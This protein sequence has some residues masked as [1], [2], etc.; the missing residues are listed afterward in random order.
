LNY[1]YPYFDIKKAPFLGQLSLRIVSNYI[2][3]VN[4]L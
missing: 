4:I 3:G 2:K 1:F